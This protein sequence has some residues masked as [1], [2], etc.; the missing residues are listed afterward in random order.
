MAKIKKPTT[1]IVL[2]KDKKLA[3]GKHPVML[4]ITFNRK[5]KYYALKGDQGTITC[6]EKKWN[7]SIGRF[8]RN[9]EFNHFLDQ[10]ELRAK[11][12][13]RELESIDFTF[14]AFENKY[15]RRYDRQKVISYFDHLIEKLTEEGRLGSANSYK[16]TRNRITEFKPDIHFQDLDY[17]FLERFEKYLLAKGNSINSIGIYMRTLRAV[18]NKA[19]AEDL[20]KEE[21][22]P[23]KK[24]KI[25]TGNATKRA[26]TKAD[27]LKI[28]R[29][30]TEKG[31]SQWHSL[32]L[33]TF[34]YLTRGMNLKDMALLTW[35]KNIV[36]DKIVYVRA[37]TTNTKKTL[38]P[39]IIKIEP[40]IDKIL[41]RY[42]KKSDYV[43]PILE[44]GLTESTIRHRVKNML[45]KISADITEI[46]KDLKI[47]CANQI[48]H[49]WARHTYATTLK[50]SGISTAVIS[51]ALGHASE[52]TTKAYLDKFEQSEIDSTYQHLI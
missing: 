9:K 18:F 46:A 45:K 35:K 1:K 47:E 31:S 29:Y 36:G 23:F 21:L 17:H 37:K 28:I 32:N 27:M 38:D 4:R 26:L 43:F 42:P 13:L 11:E 24:Y 16:D 20:V 51:E 14:V 40:E 44:P 39:H 2:R 8:N 19:I 33:F 3:N 25:K 15:F 22:Y 50:R 5:P 34:S 41:R 30:K 12:V 7:S 52:A 6:E 48:T 10:Y 49:Y